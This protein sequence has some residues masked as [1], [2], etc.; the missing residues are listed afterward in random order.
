MS[1]SKVTQLQPGASRKE[2]EKELMEILQCNAEEIVVPSDRVRKEFNKEKLQRLAA[3]YTR[4]GQLQPGVCVRDINGRFCLVAG[5]RRLRA[6][7]IAK[8]PFHFV[9]REEADEALLLEIELEEN[10][11]REGLAWQEEVEGLGKLHRLREGQKE[12]KGA[13]QSLDD[14]AMEVERSRASVHRDLELAEWAKEFPEV[15]EAKTKN[16]AYKIIKRYKAEI[17]RNQLLK[18]A[19]A[20]EESVEGE[21]AEETKEALAEV[22]VVAGT[23]IP[24]GTLLEYDRRT[25]H[26]E[27]ETELA[28]F[29]DG[30]FGLMAFDP[31]WGGNLSQIRDKPPSKEDFDDEPDIFLDNIEQWL[32]LLYQKM[33]ENSHLYLFFGIR[34]HEAV[35]ATL[36]RV[37]FSVNRIP[38]IWYKQ[39]SH[40]TRNPELWPGRS[41]EPIAF[42][43]KGA[44]KLITLGAPDVIITPAPT[45]QMKGIH[46]NAKHPDVYLEILKRSAYPGDKVCDPMSGS[47]MFGVSCEVYRAAKHLD[48]TLI[49]RE[50]VFRELGLE[51][52]IKGYS[53]VLNREPIERPREITEYE[54]P[55]VA[56]DFHDLEIGG[57][58]WMRF[59][60]VYPEKQDEMLEWRKSKEEG[61]RM[62]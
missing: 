45:P 58:D 14:T 55:E 6:C 21:L 11:N 23:A 40:V 42:A 10:L 46:P 24:K 43:R 56:E 60:K 1:E 19:V 47:G 27:M 39:G 37:G 54:I 50:L 3:S 32:R 12:T 18:I 28:K 2:K 20:K 35:F 9:L 30:H 26:G 4:I 38:L 33:A 22:I 7:R 48:W 51:N 59:W 41:Y 15:Q 25:I 31:P 57:A 5:E 8:H 62:L 49:E 36:E 34:F 44:K 52:V 53:K 13:T 29:P 61:R 16:E 17:M